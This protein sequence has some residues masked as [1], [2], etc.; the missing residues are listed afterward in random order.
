M[1]KK[2]VVIT[3]LGTIN[4]IGINVKDFWNNCLQ[5]KTNI[6]KI[7]QHWFSYSNFNST[8]WAPIPSIDYSEH[9]ITKIEQKQLDITTLLSICAIQEAFNSAKLEYVKYNEKKNTYKIPSINNKKAGVFI[10][11]GIGGVSTLGSCWSFQILNNQKKRLDDLLN[12]NEIKNNKK[13][14]KDLSN[15][16]EKMILPNR[17][18]PFA[19]SMIMSNA[20]SANLAI[21]FDLQGTNHTYNSA[22]ASGTVAIGNGFK[23]IKNGELDIVIAGGVEYMYDEYGALF[24][25]FDT[26]KTLV[27]NKKHTDMEKANRP[28]DKDRS[29]FLYAQG[30]CGIIIT[31]ELEHAKKRNAPIIAEILSYSENCDA[32]NVM[33]IEN[34]GNAIKRMLG[35]A[36]TDANINSDQVDYINAHGTGT[37]INDEVESKIIEE[38]FGNK[39]LVNS[40]KSLI[41]HTLGASG[42]IEAVVTALS[43]KNKTT[44][45]CK[46]LKN[47]VRDLN[48]I[49][50]INT[51]P[52][53][54]AITQSFG[55]G[56]HNA[57]LILKEY[58]Q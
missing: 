30:G 52:I 14:Q 13:L 32:H 18:N 21:K 33:V 19:V 54:T 23:Q 22:C 1:D 4:P 57:C 11:T 37:I 42:A 53:K 3:G 39:I 34:S 10:G 55:F 49:T 50:K 58:T 17:F 25:A 56:G 40:T 20:S 16:Y 6:Q 9:F 31:E 41:G 48:F 5:G 2:R 43:I 36:L 8:I 28:F 24:Y 47:P 38:L 29:G 46:N 45:I 44:H 12:N 26:L 15:I 7:P 35:K 27:N 51:H